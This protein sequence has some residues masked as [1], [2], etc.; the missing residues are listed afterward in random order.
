MSPR[1]DATTR[2]IVR[3]HWRDTTAFLLATSEPCMSLREL[4]IARVRRLLVGL[5]P[6]ELSTLRLPDSWLLAV[7]LCPGDDT[8]SLVPFV[9]GLPPRDR[10]RVVFFLHPDADLVQ[11]FHAWY[12]AG[13]P[14]P[15]TLDAGDYRS[16]APKLGHELNKRI[17]LDHP[18]P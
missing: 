13:L 3:A 8:A 7:L 11:A 10:D 18:V 16:L 14:D 17:A 5:A 6:E 4:E 1:I 9:A 15:H 2:E 12:A